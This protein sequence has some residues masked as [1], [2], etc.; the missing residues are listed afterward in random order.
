MDCT[1]IFQNVLKASR[2][3]NLLDVDT[4]NQVGND[5][6]DAAVANSEIILRENEK[7]LA[8]GRKKDLSAAMLDRLALTDNVIESMITG[9][10]AVVCKM[11]PD[12]KVCQL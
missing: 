3:L 9:L 7:D 11:Q 6:A 5:V 8:N 2:T 4:I 12:E 1:P 10:Q